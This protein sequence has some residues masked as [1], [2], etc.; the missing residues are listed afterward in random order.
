MATTAEGVLSSP[1]T[2]Y[3]SRYL[4]RAIT[5]SPAGPRP[6]DPQQVITS[7]TPEIRIQCACHKVLES[8]QGGSVEIC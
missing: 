8:A 7:S 2:E 5:S 1:A 4:I 6:P 3:T